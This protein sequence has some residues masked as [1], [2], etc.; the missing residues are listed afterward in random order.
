MKG[1][2]VNLLALQLLGHCIAV[3]FVIDL[4]ISNVK[5]YCS[6]ISTLFHLFL[7]VNLLEW[8]KTLGQDYGVVAFVI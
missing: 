2:L 5:K 1:I 4:I 3:V 7:L 8:E 6:Y